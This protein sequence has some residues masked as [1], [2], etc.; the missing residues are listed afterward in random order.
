[1]KKKDEPAKVVGER[2]VHTTEVYTLTLTERT[3][4]KALKDQIERDS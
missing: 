3:E 4:R 1:M 2:R